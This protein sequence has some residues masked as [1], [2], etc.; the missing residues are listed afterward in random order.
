VVVID[1]G[2]DDQTGKMIKRYLRKNDIGSDR[3][4]VDIKKKNE[5]AMK[6]IR[7]GVKHYC[8]NY[9]VTMILDGDDELLGSYVFKL[10]NAIYQSKN[11]G[12][13]YANHIAYNQTEK[14]T[15]LGHSS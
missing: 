15:N 2:S 3:V 9:T 7:D 14:T 10:F 6:S 13:A 5:G 11:P 4:V 12:V 1:D 8:K